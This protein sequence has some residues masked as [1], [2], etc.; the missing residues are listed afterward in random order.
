MNVRQ[1][2]AELSKLDGHVIVE[3]EDVFGMAEVTDVHLNTATGKVE[4]S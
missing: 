2:I 1:L 4:L 3:M